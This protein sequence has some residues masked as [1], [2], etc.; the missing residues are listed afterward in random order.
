MPQGHMIILR[1]SGQ[2]GCQH[3]N[4]AKI[5]HLQRGW[6]GN[7]RILFENA[8]SL[9]SEV[10]KGTL[11]TRHLCG[12]SSRLGLLSIQYSVLALVCAV[13]QVL[14]QGVLPMSDIQGG[15]ALAGRNV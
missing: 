1:V 13:G 8:V 14:S 9:C 12:C 2:P 4:L 5:V 3:G 15:D 6:T 11:C 7:G 10:A